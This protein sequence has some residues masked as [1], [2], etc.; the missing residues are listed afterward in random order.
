MS[1]N[2]NILLLSVGLNGFNLLYKRCIDSHYCYA[3]KYSY[4]YVCIDR[5]NLPLTPKESSWIK[6]PLIYEFLNSGYD[7]V[8]FVD[9]DCMINSSAPPFESL[10]TPSKSIYMALGK[11][12]RY[13]AGVFFVKNSQESKNF[14]KTV[15]DNCEFTIPEEDRLYTR[16]ENGHV[17]YF[18]KK[19]PIIQTIDKKWNNNSDTSLQDFIRHYSGGIMRKTY[20]H[21]VTEF[22]GFYIF[23]TIGKFHRRLTRGSNESLKQSLTQTVHSFIRTFI[24]DNLQHA[25]QPVS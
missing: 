10:D 13:N 5:T 7:W 18:S 9:A 14:F 3:R 6:I 2:K 19:F 20:K 23:S 12:Q 24:T 16:Y 21:T 1:G 4:R 15:F 8:G 22:L 17:I 25:N 11:S